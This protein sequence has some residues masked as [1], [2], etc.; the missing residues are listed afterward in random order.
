MGCTE[1]N[2][3]ASHPTPDGSGIAPFMLD[4]RCQY[5]KEHKLEAKDVLSNINCTQATEGAENAV[6][7]LWDLDL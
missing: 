5:K 6:F 2:L 4:V 1:G 3:K 7:Y